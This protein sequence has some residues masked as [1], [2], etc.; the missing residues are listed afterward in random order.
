MNEASD[1]RW[2]VPKVLED[3]IANRAAKSPEVIEQYLRDAVV[4]GDLEIEDCNSGQRFRWREWASR[5]DGRASYWEDLRPGGKARLNIGKFIIY[6]RA[7][8]EEYRVRVE[9]LPGISP[10]AA[11]TEAQSAKNKGGT[12][13]SWDWGR[14]EY[15]AISHFVANGFTPSDA[16]REA[17]TRQIAEWLAHWLT[18]KAGKGGEKARASDANVKTHAEKVYEVCR[19]EIDDGPS[20]LK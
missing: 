19:R 9:P 20:R 12:P 13:A 4:G 8:P 1:D 15:R 7:L 6:L 5:V 11:T 16:P 10:A 17:A 2:L 18:A 14:A 3:E